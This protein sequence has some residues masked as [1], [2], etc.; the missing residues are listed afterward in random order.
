MSEQ[1]SQ[2]LVQRI[3]DAFVRKDLPLILD[4]QADDAQWSVAANADRIPWAAPQAGREG[5]ADF[6][7]TLA[8]WLVAEQFEI[9]ETLSG[10]ET[11]VALGYQRGYV[12]PNGNPYE[13]D[14]IHVWKIREGK[15]ASFRVYYDTEYVASRL[16]GEG[17]GA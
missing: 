7:K 5:V 9:R 8:A 17:T 15:I 10:G 16:H 3:Y 13:F 14:F 4:L 6:L 11:V 1:E 12:R 2:E